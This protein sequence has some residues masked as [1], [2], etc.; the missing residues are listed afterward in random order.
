MLETLSNSPAACCHFV[1]VYI[2]GSIH[3]ASGT[4]SFSESGIDFPCG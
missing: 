3:S 4:R 1:R 2:P